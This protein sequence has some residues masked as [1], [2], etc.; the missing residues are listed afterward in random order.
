MGSWEARY[1]VIGMGS[2]AAGDA[3]RDIVGLCFFDGGCSRAC[4]LPSADGIMMWFDLVLFHGSNS[5]QDA[6][7]AG[8]ERFERVERVDW[9][10]VTELTG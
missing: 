4:T 1:A 3:R 10:E 8:G 5:E 9:V 7:G 2:A 6:E